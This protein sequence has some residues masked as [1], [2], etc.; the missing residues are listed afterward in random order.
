MQNPKYNSI[1]EEIKGT[2][3]N[4]KKVVSEY[5]KP[6]KRKAI[7]QILNSFLPFLGL[8]VAIY[9]SLDYS[10]LLSIF[11]MAVN[12]FFLVRI[13]IIQHDCGHQSFFKSKKL[14]N[15]IGTVCSVFSFIPYKYWA[16]TH[17][18]HH[19]HSGQ[20]EVHDIGDIPTLS[21]KEYRR[22]SFWKKLSYRAMRFPP[23]TFVIA[24]MFYLII[25]CRLPTI[26]FGN[27]KKW[28]W[29]QF[30]DNFWIAAA[31]IT[32]GTLIGWQ[33]FLIVQFSIILLFGIIAFWFFYVQHQHEHGYKHW[34]K[35]WDYLLS[36]IRGATYYKLP[37]VFQWLTGNIGFHHLHHLSS[38]IPNYNLEKCYKENRML[39]KYVTVV[40]FKES[41][42]MMFH[43][44]W[45][46]ERQK[47]ISFY[48]YSKMKRM[49]MV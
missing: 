32:A 37:K 3:K 22:L 7:I 28:A 46:E 4:W 38:L 36:A 49:G 14:N 43:N 12:A 16:K 27:W 18:F 1:N 23:I 34:K 6:N 39:N 30:K 47:M 11:L 8:W 29:V 17:A 25:S 5:Q 21:I 33:K 9:F 48:E 31:Y 42:G 20:L 45:D 35:N 15:F 44:L 24:P 13:F 2:L 10:I 19:G 26:S 40:T 41:L